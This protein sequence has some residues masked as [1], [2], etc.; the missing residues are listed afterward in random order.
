MVKYLIIDF[1]STFI[2]KETLDELSE[3]CLNKIPNSKQILSE[4]K[5]I[6]NKAMNGEMEFKH[7]LINRLRLINITRDDIEKVI[8]VV[9]NNITKSVSENKS[10]FI[11]YYKNIFIVSGGFKEIIAPIVYPYNVKENHIIANSFLYKG[12]NVVGCNQQNDL[13]K[14]RGKV[15]AVNKLNLKGEIIVVGDGYTDYEIKKYNAAQ[16]FIAF[17][18]NILRQSVV[19]KSDVIADNFNVVINEFLK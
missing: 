12:P 10:F 6:T 14:N 8:R 19:E 5:S 15:I 2:R 9:K 7:A 16:T 11:K 18:E 1:D 3:I 13:L 17:T 4:M